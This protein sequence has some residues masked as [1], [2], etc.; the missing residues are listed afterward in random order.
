[1]NMRTIWHC[2]RCGRELDKGLCADGT[3]VVANHE[4]AGVTLCSHC[5]NKFIDVFQAWL[6]DPDL[7]DHKEEIDQFMYDMIE[8]EGD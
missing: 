2:E 1:M 4:V 3:Y 7:W 5:Y 6:D 8:T